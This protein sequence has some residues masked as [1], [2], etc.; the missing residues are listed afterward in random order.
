[1]KKLVIQT[2]YRENYSAWDWDGQGEC[3]QGWKNK[4]GS[5]YVLPN[6][7]ATIDVDAVVEAISSH[8]TTDNNYTMEYIISAEV[9]DY[10]KKVCEDWETITEF[11][12]MGET[13]AFMK[14]TDNREGGWM[15]REILE[16]IETWT[17]GES[18]MDRKNYS[19]E[20]LMEDGDFCKEQE[21][22]SL[23]FKNN[24]EEVA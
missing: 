12:L 10:N 14:V 22:L 21:E 13:P 19:V 24:V 9:V 15:R 2:Q 18:Y 6:C 16:K 11:T 1:M 17:M 5:T 3:P 20:F 8:I 23:W 7:P 4:G